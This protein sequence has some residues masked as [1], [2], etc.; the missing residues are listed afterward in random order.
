MSLTVGSLFAGIGGFD[1]GFERSGIVPVWQVEKD[2]NC[3]RILERHWPD[4]PRYRDVTE[5]GKSTTT[6][7]PDII[8]GGFPCQDISVAG[9]RA[10]LAGERSGLWYEYARILDEF[11][12]SWVCIENVAGLLSSWSAIEP[13][14]MQIPSD[15][16]EGWEIEVEES[17]DLETILFELEKLGYRWLYSVSDSQWFGVPQRR[18]RVFIIGHLGNRTGGLEV[19]FEP[20]SM[21]GDSPP[22]R[23]EKSR[24][25]STLT[26]GVRVS[27]N[28][29]GRR[30]EDDVN[31]VA[32]TLNSGGN[33]GGFRTEPGEHLVADTFRICGFGDYAASASAS[34]VKARDHKDATDLIAYQCQ[35]SNVGPMGTLRAGNGNETGGVPFVWALHSENSNAGK[36]GVGPA[37]AD[38]ARC[39]DVNGGYSTSQG[40]NLVQ[41]GPEMS[42]RRLTPRECERLQG[43]PDDWT[44]FDSEGKQLSDSARYRALGNAATVNV[45]EWIGSRFPT[46]G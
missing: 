46:S 21:S 14:A 4:V 1:L 13:E 2:D 9:C 39:L 5:F 3:N 37:I 15:A 26:S 38:R 24:I 32:A 22:S 29:P 30:R 25:A 23:E 7:Q 18:R 8:C 40:G 42:V 43:F 41:G 16:S 27:G 12:P 31:I 33:S 44:R 17:S 35:G 36:N 20:E 11:R 45:T 19:L 10:G 34:A 28:A 6:V